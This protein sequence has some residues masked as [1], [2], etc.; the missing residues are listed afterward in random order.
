MGLLLPDT[1][2]KSNDRVLVVAL[3]VLL[4]SAVLLAWSEVPAPAAEEAAVQTPAVR[5]MNAHNS[6]NT[7][8]WLKGK[9][10]Q[11]ESA[12]LYGEAL[13]NFNKL[14]ADYPQWQ[15]DLVAFRINYCRQALKGLSGD[16]DRKEEVSDRRAA[17]TDRPSEISGQ[18]SAV[19]DRKSQIENR[20]SATGDPQSA[21][22]GLSP[23]NAKLQQAVLLERSRDCAGALAVYNAILEEFPKEPSALKGACRCYL[24]FERIN[25]ARALARQALTLA[26]PDAEMYFLAALADCCGGRYQDALPLLRQSLKQNGTCPEAHVALGVAL[27]ATGQAAEAQKEFKRSLAFN[28]RLSDAYY[29]LARLSLTQKPLGRDTARVHYQIALRYGAIPDPELDKLL[30]E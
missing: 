4:C 3:R 23:L 16:G 8:D 25:L 9:G 22:L 7:A 12:D 10:M 30:A 1:A 20:K 11:A 24:R 26:A 14:A 29:N 6:M 18:H 27:A 15:P 17:V 2:A 5:F 28:P 21:T 13:D 19:S